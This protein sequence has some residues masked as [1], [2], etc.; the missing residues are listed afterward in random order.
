MRK[1]HINNQ[2]WKY[3]IGK[4][5][6]VIESPLGEKQVVPFNELMNMNWNDIERATWKRYFIIKPSDVKNYIESHI[7]WNARS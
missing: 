5:H 4:Q 6:L 1:V 2:E 7:W 3:K